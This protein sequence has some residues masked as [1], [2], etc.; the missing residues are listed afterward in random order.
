MFIGNLGAFFYLK[1]LW[2][3]RGLANLDSAGIHVTSALMSCVNSPVSTTEVKISALRAL[4]KKKC[5]SKVLKLK[6][7]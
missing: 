4:G 1:A 3:I 7:F 2:A 6:I 5:N